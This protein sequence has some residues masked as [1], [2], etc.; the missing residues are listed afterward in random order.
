MNFFGNQGHDYDCGGDKNCGCCIDP[1]L[2]L[3]LLVCGGGKGCGCNVDCCSIL[4]IIILLSVCGGCGGRGN[5]HG[6]GKHYD[7][8]DHQC[9]GCV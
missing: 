5:G 1:C 4:W 2:L 8:D 6:H 7:Y 3:L 9:D